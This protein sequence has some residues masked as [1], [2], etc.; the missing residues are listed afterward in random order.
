MQHT[1]FLLRNHDQGVLWASAGLGFGLWKTQGIC[2]PSDTT[3]AAYQ[4]STG[5][6]SRPQLGDS[7][8]T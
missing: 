5:S 3:L 8:L 1:F 6:Y 2:K 7:Q 4:V